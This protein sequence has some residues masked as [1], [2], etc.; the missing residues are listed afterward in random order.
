[1]EVAPAAP[2]HVRRTD[3]EEQQW[4]GLEAYVADLDRHLVV[5]REG[6]QY[7]QETD[8]A[9]ASND[10]LVSEADPIYVASDEDVD[11]PRVTSLLQ[12]NIGG[13]T[14]ETVRKGLRTGYVYTGSLNPE[15]FKRLGAVYKRLKEAKGIIGPVPTQMSEDETK[16]DSSVTFDLASNTLVGFCGDEG[17]GH[18]CSLDGVRDP[19]HNGK[20]LMNP[21]DSATRVLAMGDY[22]AH[23]SHVKA[24]FDQLPFAQH[25]LRA[26][27]VIW[28]YVSVF[29]SSSWTLAERAEAASF[30]L[31]FL[32]LW[33]SWLL[34]AERLTL[35]A[36]FIS[37]ECYEDITISVHNVI[38]IIR[39]GPGSASDS[40]ESDTDDD[41][42][43]ETDHPHTL[44]AKALAAIQP[45][46]EELSD[47]PGLATH[48]FDVVEDDLGVEQEVIVGGISRDSD[49]ARSELRAVVD[50]LITEAISDAP[51]EGEP[52]MVTIECEGGP[53]PSSSRTG[54]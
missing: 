17:D 44:G 35:K 47:H 34:R 16:I 5:D 30:V 51:T 32:R 38:L 18:T 45:S 1:M 2:T 36:N 46:D 21:L 20:K 26:N 40:G 9:G 12:L 29:F 43:D 53:G 25:G 52:A 41:D 24:V 27:D 13:P 3:A 11:G 23:M 42:G 37:R 6:R 19:I 48:T 10:D 14:V 49:N 7:M 28:N 50:T 22:M 54:A 15:A 31:H 4:L 39:S 33:R 8:A